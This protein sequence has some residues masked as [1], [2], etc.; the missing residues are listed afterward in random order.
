[1]EFVFKITGM[2]CQGCADTIEKGFASDSK[3]LASTVSLEN[4]ELTIESDD[5]LWVFADGEPMC[6]IPAT[7][8]VVPNVLRIRC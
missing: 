5:A 3:I 2:T 4:N 6:E 8:E 7:I 1:M